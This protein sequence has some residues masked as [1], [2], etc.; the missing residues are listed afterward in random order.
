MPAALPAGICGQPS[1]DPPTVVVEACWLAEERPDIEAGP[2]FARSRQTESEHLATTA[3]D[4]A[5]MPELVRT[6]ADLPLGAV[7]AS[8]AVAERLE[9]TDV[10]TLDWRTSPSSVPGTWPPLNLLP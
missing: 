3:T 5:R 4:L 1:A 10:A 2:S 8:I 9:L 7:D 6:N